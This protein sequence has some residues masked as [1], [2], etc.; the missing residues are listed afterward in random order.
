MRPFAANAQTA[1]RFTWP[2]KFHDPVWPKAGSSVRLHFADRCGVVAIA[3]PQQ[4]SGAE[5]GQ[6]AAPKIALA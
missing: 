6:C 4:F 1:W 3:T 2:Y 5:P